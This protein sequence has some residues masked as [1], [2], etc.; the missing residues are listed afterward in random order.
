MNHII[1]FSNKS[2]QKS[3]AD[4]KKII[5]KTINFTLEYEGFSDLAEVSVTLINNEGIQ[6]LN[7]K[8]R[9]KDN[10]TDV[11]SF[12]ASELD[13]ELELNPET[14]A[15][16]LGDVVISLEMADKQA[17]EYGHSLEREVSFLTVHSILHLLGFDH[18]ISKDEE[19]IMFSK[20]E[21]ILNQLGFIRM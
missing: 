1:S 21:E 14:N 2:K 17:I 16:F 15:Y 11:L 5:V 6:K 9:N 13:E 10:P 12:P 7:N 20:Q 18:E 19:Q 8:F 3:V 4:L